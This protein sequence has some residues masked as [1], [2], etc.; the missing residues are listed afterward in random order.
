MLLRAILTSSEGSHLEMIMRRIVDIGTTDLERIVLDI[1]R[2]DTTTPRRMEADQSHGRRRRLNPIPP[3]THR[4]TIH[5]GRQ[6]KGLLL[7]VLETV[8]MCRMTCL[9]PNWI[10]RNYSATMMERMIER[11][12]RPA[13]I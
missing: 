5:F 7:L 12:H 13:T 8:I 2:M 4:F 11:L 1:R 10:D 6:T 3:L 9:V